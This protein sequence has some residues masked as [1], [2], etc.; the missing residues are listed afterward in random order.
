MKKPYQGETHFARVSQQV[1]PAKTWTGTF[2]HHLISITLAGGT[3]YSLPEEKISVG[4][5]DLLHFAPQAWQSWKSDA[6]TGWTA[7]FVIMDIPPRLVSLL[8]P[9]NMATGIGRMHLDPTSLQTAATCFATID[10]WINSPSALTSNLIVNQL[11]YI[12][13]LTRARLDTSTVDPRIEKARTFLHSRIEVPTRL[14][15][16]A[17]A[18][19]LSRARLCALFKDFLHTSPLQY[20]EDLRMQR[21][22]QL[23]RF[24]ATDINDVAKAMGYHERKYFDKRFKRHW[25]VTPFQYRKQ[26]D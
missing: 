24:T 23:L 4:V 9:D 11:E 1:E 18:A 16:V 13:L 20:L 2:P 12:L 25:Q 22:A 14:E 5:G 10:G 8:P 15:E 21:A 19:N 3:V 6:D 7:S 26:V 17:R